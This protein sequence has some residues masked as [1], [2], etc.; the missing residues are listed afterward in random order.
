MP[1]MGL[2]SKFGQT[3]ERDFEQI[4]I[5]GLGK[6]LVLEKPVDVK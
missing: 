4:K 3:L 2:G 5:M 1:T 6:T